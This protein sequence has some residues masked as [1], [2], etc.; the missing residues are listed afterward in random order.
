MIYIAWTGGDD[1]INATIVLA[2][3]VMIQKEMKNMIISFG[4]L[5]VVRSLLKCLLPSVIC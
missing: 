2:K 4:P 3:D 1:K 5:I